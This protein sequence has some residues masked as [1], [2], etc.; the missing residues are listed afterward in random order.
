MIILFPVEKLFFR[1]RNSKNS[2]MRKKIDYLYNVAYKYYLDIYLD[3]IAKRGIED[4][5]PVYYITG[6]ITCRQAQWNAMCVMIQ[7]IQNNRVNH[8][9]ISRIESERGK[10]GK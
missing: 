6:R 4:Y 9:Y 10:S 2:F 1:L 5:H 3:N 7:V 8:C